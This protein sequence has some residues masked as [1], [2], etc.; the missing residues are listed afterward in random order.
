MALSWKPALCKSLGAGVGSF[1][2][3]CNAAVPEGDRS[4]VRTL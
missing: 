2:P 3:P 1:S 4:P